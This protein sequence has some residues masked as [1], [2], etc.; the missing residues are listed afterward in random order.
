LNL[1]SS[2]LGAFTKVSIARL[3]TCR[4]FLAITVV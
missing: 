2:C 3:T 1:R 4:T